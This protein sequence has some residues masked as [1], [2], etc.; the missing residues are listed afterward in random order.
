MTRSIVATLIVALSTGLAF[1][2]EPK[3][4]QV[5]V[6]LD[7]S[8]IVLKTLGPII[9]DEE[10]TSFKVKRWFI[11]GLAITRPVN[12]KVVV[13]LSLTPAYKVEMEE[14]WGLSNQPLDGDLEL[15][16]STPFIIA[17]NGQYYPFRKGLFLGA[18]VQYLS[19]SD[20][21]MRLTPVGQNLIVG[22][23]PY[24]SA[25][26][27]EWNYK[28]ALAPALSLGY[29]QKWKGG[30]VAEFSFQVPIFSSPYHED[31]SVELD[32]GDT[33]AE[34]DLRFAQQRIRDEVFYYPVQLRIQIGR[35]WF[36]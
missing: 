21:E 12:K 25:A 31:I 6:R 17:L 36:N 23:S 5:D 30:W 29:T 20:Y 14:Q 1:A 3:M 4:S 16:Y 22:G 27:G 10:I 18:G 33:I 28:S 7:L 35:T 11:P 26:R 32:N 8:G 24:A 19:K 15:N 13:G 34:Q 2:Q 9:S